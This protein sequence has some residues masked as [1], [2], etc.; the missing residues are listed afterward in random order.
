MT[1]REVIARL[2]AYLG[3]ELGIV[4]VVRIALHLF[5][6]EPCRAY[7]RT[8]RATVRVGGEV[9]RVEMPEEMKR[10][11]RVF[12]SERRPERSR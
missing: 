4:D 12:L 1:C 3:R 9:S 2:S 6:C 10:R 5:S 8:F 7:L 11:L